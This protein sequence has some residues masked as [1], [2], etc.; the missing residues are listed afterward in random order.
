MIKVISLGNRVARAPATRRVFSEKC[1]AHG[2]RT[3]LRPQACRQQQQQQWALRSLTREFSSRGRGRASRQHRWQERQQ[4]RVRKANKGTAG[5][6]GAAVLAGVVIWQV[7]QDEAPYTHRK[8]FMIISRDGEFLKGISK[9]NW[10]SV[11]EECGPNILPSTHQATQTVERI[12][13]R[14]AQASGLK[15]CTWEFIVV[16][17]DS[18]NAFV[19]PGGKVVVFTGLL[20]VTP[21]ED[22]LASV[23][24]H[25]VGHVVANHA[26][27]KLSKSFL[28]EG[29]L[30]LLFAVTGFEYFDVARSIGGLVFDLP[31]SREMELEADFIGL[32]LMSK[33]CFDPHEMPETFGRMEATT[34]EKGISKGPAYLSTHPADAERIAKQKEWM[35]SAIQTRQQSGCRELQEW[36]AMS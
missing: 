23:L 24:G 31:N 34:K 9:S 27:E 15:G 32:Q 29:L 35:D 19:L 3:P 36:R 7:N 26:G 8:R 30:L 33:A 18:M 5:A 17:D 21:N 1:S 11:K 13:K 25:E 12:G 6:C 20:E 10:A 28:K 2:T 4:Q 16:R 14:I 22:A